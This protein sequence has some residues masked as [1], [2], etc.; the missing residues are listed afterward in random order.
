MPM[1]LPVIILVGPPNLRKESFAN[2]FLNY[3]PK[4][5]I[6]NTDNVYDKLEYSWERMFKYADIIL[7]FGGWTENEVSGVQ[8]NFPKYMTWSGD[9]Y[10]TMKRIQEYL[11]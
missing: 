11:Q 9:D 3:N 8:S 7:D 5:F 2:L 6:I 10:E 1:L 4:T